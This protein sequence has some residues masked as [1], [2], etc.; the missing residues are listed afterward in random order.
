M[1][2]F[3]AVSIRWSVLSVFR[4]AKQIC[5][6]G[7]WFKDSVY[8]G[9]YKRTVHREVNFIVFLF[10]SNLAVRDCF[11]DRN[12]LIIITQW[13]ELVNLFF[14]LSVRNWH[15]QILDG[16]SSSTFSWTSSNLHNLNFIWNFVLNLRG[17]TY[18][19]GL[20]SKKCPQ[21]ALRPFW[22]K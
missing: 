6:V 19:T 22:K 13:L 1:V 5:L 3:W 20:F 10:K 2:D 16:K 15:K 4:I 18:I 7:I 21:K 9:N 14:W 8:G 12:C 17:N 11:I